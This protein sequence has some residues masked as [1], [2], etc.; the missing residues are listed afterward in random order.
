MGKLTHL[1]GWDAKLSSISIDAGNLVPATILEYVPRCP[2]CLRADQV[3]H[4]L[5]VE[6]VKSIHSH[7]CSLLSA[8]YRHTNLSM[9]A[10]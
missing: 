5:N 6:N 7:V 2:R 3:D 1:E 4:S 9:P 8:T 10:H